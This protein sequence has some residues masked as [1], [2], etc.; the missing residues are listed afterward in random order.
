[1]TQRTS[2]TVRS[3]VKA[4]AKHTYDVV[5]PIDPTKF[6]P[7]YGPIP[8]VTAVHNQSGSWDTVARTRQLELA[9]GGHV[10]E[11]ITDADSPQFFAYDLSDFQR[12]FGVLVAGAR[13]EWRFAELD[14]GTE[15]RWTYSFYALQGR[16]WIVALIVKMFWGPYMRRVISSLS[17]EVDS[18]TESN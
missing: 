6:F 15:I 5:C 8:G 2:V 18:A 16:G 9:D 7:G 1:M 14:N 12:L 11:E 13:A 4:T 17:A 10:I 3:I